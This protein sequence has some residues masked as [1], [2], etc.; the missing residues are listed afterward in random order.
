MFT[1]PS[2]PTRHI[3]VHRGQHGQTDIDPTCMEQRI[4]VVRDEGQ[5]THGQKGLGD[6]EGRAAPL[7]KQGIAFQAKGT[8]RAKAEAGNN[9]AFLRS[10]EKPAVHGA[11][12]AGGTT[13]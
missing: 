3:S 2:L 8:E 12:G 13:R 10:G 6:C 9:L 5:R 1:E 11:C 4:P 7:R